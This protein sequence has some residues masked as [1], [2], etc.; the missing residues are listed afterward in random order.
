MTILEAVSETAGCASAKASE[1]TRIDRTLA[2]SSLWRDEKPRPA[3]RAIQ[4]A[5]TSA[6]SHSGQSDPSVS[7]MS[8]RNPPLPRPPLDGRER[9]RDAG[10]KHPPGPSWKVPGAVDSRLC[11]Q[12]GMRQVRQG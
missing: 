6:S 9:Q 5:G 1:A 11:G 2:C 7:D 3:V 10:S 8:H 12:I 4:T